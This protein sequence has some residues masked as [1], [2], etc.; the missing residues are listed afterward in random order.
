MSSLDEL[1]YDW[2]QLAEQDALWAILTDATKSGG[3]WDLAEFMATGKAEI[4]T[5]MSY[6][7]RINCRPDRKGTVLDFGCG[8]G[9]VTQALAPEFAACVGLDISE[10][11]IEKATAL[12]QFRNCRYVASSE[13]RL[14]FEDESFA[15][16]YSNI[17]LQHV[18]TQFAAEYLGEFVRTLA[19][20]GV[21]VFGVQDNLTVLSSLL[22]R[23]RKL[24][25][26]RSRI[27]RAL[28]RSVTN[29]QMYCLPEPLV[30]TALGNSTIVDIQY[31][32]TGAKDY[33][34]NLTY[35]PRPRLTGYSG[36]QY[37]VVKPR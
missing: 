28:G 8:V 15:F 9:R 17:V 33:N 20:G 31:T 21:L 11:M 6:L 23:A 36:R 19:P 18:P 29:M 37:C 1:R 35:L 26:L 4:A 25:Q 24:I 30:R 14:P 27:K 13:S 16:I 3:K 5:V 10:Q 32:N 2:E 12:N 22:K 7:S 34:G